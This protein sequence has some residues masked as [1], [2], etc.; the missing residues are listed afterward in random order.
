M[1]QRDKVD[2]SI[3]A[4]GLSV[5]VRNP[6]IFIFPL[7][8]IVVKILLDFLSGPIFDPL[9]G[10]DFG[11]IGLLGN[12]IDGFAFA[13]AIIAA[14]TAWRNRRPTLSETWDEGRRK[15]GGILMATLGF[16]FMIYVAG[17]LGG[18]L[19]P[20]GLILSAAAFYFLIYT[21]PAAAIGGIPG[22][23][24]LQASIDRVKSNY[25]AAAVLAVVSIVLYYYLV[26]ILGVYL[27]EP[28]G[29]YAGYGI[30]V[31]GAI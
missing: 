10:R 24:A 27:T 30:K 2:V 28:L 20:L 15:A 31:L 11:I 18:Y 9:G 14:E 22:G 4:R 7:V 19:G 29:L 13:L 5:L 17:M 21:I 3:Y 8:A 12:L 16:F 23:A 25:L 1:N 6:V 26:L